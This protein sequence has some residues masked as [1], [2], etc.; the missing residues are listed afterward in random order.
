MCRRL[1]S[2]FATGELSFRRL[3]NRSVFAP[4]N[5]DA[6]IAQTPQRRL[7]N[8]EFATFAQG[9]TDPARDWVQCGFV[10]K[11]VPPNS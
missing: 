6:S 8:P 1:E 3:P 11:P 10:T 5:A 7:D 9:L 4:H 2:E